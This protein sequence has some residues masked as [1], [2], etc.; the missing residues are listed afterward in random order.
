ML[1][2]ANQHSSLFEFQPNYRLI[3]TLPTMTDSHETRV[4]AGYKATLSFV[5]Y[6][7]DH[8]NF[9]C[10]D[11]HFSNPNVS[12][13]AKAHAEKVLADAGIDIYGIGLAD[14]KSEHEHRVLG[15]YKS[16]LSFVYFALGECSS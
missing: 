11:P 7:S 10:A 5:L 14:G 6:H 4:L 12:P 13:E 2:Q 16:T 15:G 9:V 8:F 1:E 3:A